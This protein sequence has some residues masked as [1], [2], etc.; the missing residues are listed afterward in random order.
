MN[1]KKMLREAMQ[2]EKQEAPLVSKKK[3]AKKQPKK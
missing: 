2:A 1:V 3:P